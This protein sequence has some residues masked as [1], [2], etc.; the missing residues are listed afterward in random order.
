MLETGQNV[1]FGQ[2][3]GVY[4]LVVWAA[5]TALWQVLLLNSEYSSF[6]VVITEVISDYNYKQ[7]SLFVSDIII[8]FIIFNFIMSICVWITIK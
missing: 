5:L 8:S 4:Q 1:K 7:S 3:W 6:S 2:C